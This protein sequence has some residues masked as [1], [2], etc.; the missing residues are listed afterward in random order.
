MEP[1]EIQQLIRVNPPRV[2]AGDV[3]Y[4]FLT[5]AVEKF[6]TIN[7]PAAGPNLIEAL[8]WG[9]NGY[10]IRYSL[11]LI[12][13]IYATRN[14]LLDP[15]EPNYVIPDAYMREY[16]GGNRSATFYRY[17][18][19]NEKIHRMLMGDA[20]NA[21]LVDRPLNTFEVIQR[22]QPDFNPARFHIYYFQNIIATNYLTSKYLASHL[23]IPGYQ[24]IYTNVSS[25]NILIVLG[26]ELNL[27]KRAK[28]AWA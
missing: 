11:I 14:Q 6:G 3:L 12:L 2:Y 10:F 21:G 4:N 25:Q 9:K 23:N 5:D 20:V 24:E 18:D 19:N 22:I 13:H 1:A 26:G 16:F 8:A 7:G 17:R 15:H 28:R 27:I